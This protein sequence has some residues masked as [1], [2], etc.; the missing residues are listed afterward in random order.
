MKVTLFIKNTVILVAT[1]LILRSVGIFFR[2]WLADKI[3][4]EGVGLYQLIFSVYMLAATFATSGISTAVTRLVADE[5]HKGKKAL[6]RIMQRAF[7]ITATAALA[8]TAIIFFG[9]KPIAICMLKDIRAVISLKILSFSLP[10]MGFS[11]VLRG[12]FI[13]RRK[14]F[15]PSIVQL[16][17]QAVR[18]IV[19]VLLI[20]AT[21]KKG[22]AYTSA[23]VLLGD[24]LA[25][26]A[27]AAVNY[28]LYRLDVRKLE[29]QGTVSGLFRRIMHIAIPITGSGYLSSLLHT[30]ENL[31]V[32]LKL[33]VFHGSR[34]RSL[35][36]FGAVRGMALPVLFFPASFLSS[37]S[38][39]L[40]PEVSSA[41]ALGQQEKVRELVS[42]SVALTLKLSTF[43]ACVFMFNAENIGL[44]VYSDSDV[45]GVIRILSPIVP[46]MYLESVSAGLLK[47]LDCQMNMLKVNTVDSCIRIA[48]VLLV[49]PQFGIKGYLGIMLVSNCFTSSL[50]TRC[51]FKAANIKP[52]PASWVALP[53]AVGVSGGFLGSLLSSSLH[54]L[55]LKLTV[56][57]GAQLFLFGVYW[58]ITCKREKSVVYLKVN[59]P[60]HGV[61]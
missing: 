57:I 20:G 43:I 22:L 45:G 15:Q 2:V 54:N 38:T 61:L 13:A 53:L 59:K 27:S 56:A 14:T 11:S 51:L 1:S 35:E 16:F 24:T 58:L 26:T 25:E 33:K 44:A 3:G 29:G 60:K 48:S 19:V 18:I 52:K 42:K 50:C 21:A 41:S 28:L 32:P 49:L 55:Y 8:S 37:L 47:G 4:S 7:L 10:F 40:I 46:F 23:A 39:M 6:N 12:Y 30:A 36:L 9:A 17:E 34:E 5:E 31:L